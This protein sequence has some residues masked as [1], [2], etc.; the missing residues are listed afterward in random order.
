MVVTGRN[1]GPGIVNTR[2]RKPVVLL[3]NGGSRSG[4]EILAYGFEKYG[5]GA[6]VGTRTKGD[7]LAARAFMLSD[8]SLLELAVDDVRV[9]GERL[10]GVGVAPTI[11]V[12]FRLEY[13]AGA[14]PQLERAVEIAAQAPRG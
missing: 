11:E 4:K 1:G 13:S 2:W 7:V 6:V 12:P 10:E 9:D 8:G 5:Y 14:D 3:I